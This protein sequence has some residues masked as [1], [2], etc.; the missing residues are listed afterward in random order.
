MRQHDS[1]FESP[2]GY[3]QAL[4]VD[5]TALKLNYYDF[6]SNKTKEVTGAGTDFVFQVATQTQGGP[7]V[8]V[9]VVNSL[10]VAAGELMTVKGTRPLVI[11]SA[12]TTTLDGNLFVTSGTTPGPTGVVNSAGLNGLGPGGGKAGMNSM[13]GGG[14]GAGSYCSV[15]GRGGHSFQSQTGGAAG[16]T[17]GN[18]A[19]VPLQ[20]GS[21]GGRSRLSGCSGEGG[22]AVQLVAGEAITVN[23]YISAPGAGGCDG[24]DWGGS[25]AG[26]GGAILIEAPSVTL[27]GTL[28]VN[29]GGGGGYSSPGKQGSNSASP[30]KGAFGCEG[31][32]AAGAVPAKAGIDDGSG[33][34]NGP[35]GGGG[36][37]GW[38]RV[39]TSSGSMTEGPGLV[40]SPAASTNCAS[41]G[42]LSQ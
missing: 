28:A 5:T 19:I 15:G 10:S 29:G 35:A 16:P 27:S 38:I 6:P 12:T 34:C 25:G 23:G 18:A 37:V 24:S 21:S 9:L 22:G 31:D 30:A 1:S 14:S 7:E 33:T 20:G 13:Y 41:V 3:L 2:Y 4:D 42:T 11:V 32:G 40:L 26:S 17:Y 36:G 8:A 39:N